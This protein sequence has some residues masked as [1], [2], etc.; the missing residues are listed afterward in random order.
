MLYA[1]RTHG[2]RRAFAARE[3]DKVISEEKEVTK[4]VGGKEEKQM[5]TWNY[6]KL[7]PFDW[8][9]YNEALVQ[10]REIGS[11]LRAMMPPATKEGG[12]NFFN[13]YSSTS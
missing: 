7:K 11:G 13:I 9:T 10:T 8:I 12:E 6:F 3:I 4:V 5:K 1:A 2:N